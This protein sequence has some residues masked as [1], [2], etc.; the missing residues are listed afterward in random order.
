MEVTV[1][2]IRPLMNVLLL[3]SAQ[4]DHVS[5]TQ[6]ADVTFPRVV[7]DKL[8]FF[9]Y[10]SVS[11]YCNKTDDTEWKV[12]RTLTGTIPTTYSH[13][14]T[15]TSAF[16]I[17]P[18]FFRHSGK[19]WC[20]NEKGERSEAVNITVTGGSVVLE[21]PVHPVVEGSSVTL[22]CRKRK[23][24]SSSI[25]EFYKDGVHVKTGY[26]GELTISNVSVSDEGLYKCN[27]SG[28]G[29][30]SESRLAVKVFS[31]PSKKTNP[32]QN[33]PP[34]LQ[35]LLWIII[36]SVLLVS[37]LLLVMGL[38][39]WRKTNDKSS[40]GLQECKH[41]TAGGDSLVDADHATYAVVKKQKKKTV[42]REDSDVHPA[43]V[44]YAV[45]KKEKKK[46]PQLARAGT[47]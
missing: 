41:H 12:M 36:I 28:A 39:L 34:K 16:T 44:T 5:F 14:N 9:E 7:P 15:L 18:A 20:E 23:N 8:Q 25:A 43:N 1:F 3:L 21:S 29:E 30:S 11:I 35:S 13:W 6:K 26:R 22:R 27:I 24:A 17:K 47:T 10:D 42:S 37:L 31:V 46:E 19:Y 2:C 40:P 38:L 33:H 32:P 4:A 45:V